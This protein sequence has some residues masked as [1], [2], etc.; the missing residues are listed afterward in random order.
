VKK[1]WLSQCQAFQH[2]EK[3]PHSSQ[4]NFGSTE[5]IF[6]QLSVFE[7]MERSLR[8]IANKTP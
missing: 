7:N 3:F 1:Q 2:P 6:N 8:L 5:S 4:L